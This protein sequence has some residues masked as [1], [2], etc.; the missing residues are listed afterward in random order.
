MKKL[1]TLLGSFLI[2][3]LILTLPLFLIFSFF[4]YALHP[5]NSWAVGEKPFVQMIVFLVYL[6]VLGL[7]GF[8]QWKILSIAITLIRVK[9]IEE[10]RFWGILLSVVAIGTLSI[11]VN[12]VINTLLFAHSNEELGAIVYYGF[13]FS[14]V[15]VMFTFGEYAIPALLYLGVGKKYSEV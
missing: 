10:S 14:W 13:K 12:I 5:A 8:V 11:G 1:N 7:Y 3:A 9:E 6:L 4:L 2:V 15:F